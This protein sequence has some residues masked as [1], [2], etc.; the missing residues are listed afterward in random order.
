MIDI[1][2]SV[3]LTHPDI[4][5]WPRAPKAKPLV[6]PGRHR[7]FAQP[8]PTC[9]AFREAVFVSVRTYSIWPPDSITA[10]FP[11]HRAGSSSLA[12]AGP[13]SNLE[14]NVGR[15]ERAVVERATQCFYELW[16]E[17][18][19]YDLSELFEVVFWP[20]TPGKSSCGSCGNSTGTRSSRTPPQTRTC[21]SRAS[22]SMAS[23][24]LRLIR[25]TGGVIVADEV[26]LGK[27]FIAGELLQTYRERR[28]RALLIQI[29]TAFDA[30]DNP[31][32]AAPLGCCIQRGSTIFVM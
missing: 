17:A 22:R 30:G 8:Q 9:L 2:R 18:G 24:A 6:R 23:R 14:L 5:S 19:P 20:R 13:T 29:V 27:A 21:R 26:E 28:Q 7:L 10:R 16:D 4:A 1:G 25:D 12:R 3:K 31:P 11:A 15:Y 32:D